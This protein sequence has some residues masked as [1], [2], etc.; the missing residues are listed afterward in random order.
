VKLKINANV[1]LPDDS[2]WSRAKDM[3]LVA[4]EAAA[5][6][7]VRL[8]G[9]TLDITI[10]APR[11]ATIPCECRMVAAQTVYGPYSLD[12]ED[13]LRGI[14]HGGG[15]DAV[16]EV[17]RRISHLVTTIEAQRVKLSAANQDLVTY[18]A[19]LESVR[20]DRD[21]LTEES[22]ATARRIC[23]LVAEVDALK[24]MVP[25][26]ADGHPLK[27]GDR[28]LWVPFDNAFIIVGGTTMFGKFDKPDAVDLSFRPDEIG[29]FVPPTPPTP[30][31]ESAATDAAQE[32]E[33]FDTANEV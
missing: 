17:E 19:A 7:Y 27:P 32:P 13:T 20:S 11:P 21:R 24:A 12:E 33:K 25:H 29:N 31:V 5:G 15:D 3:F 30:T 22:F 8:D 9:E 23:S 16:F 2:A 4:R 26:S 18:R 1:T 28:V 14:V 10:G 6:Y